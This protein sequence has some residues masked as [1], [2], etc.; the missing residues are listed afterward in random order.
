MQRGDILSLMFVDLKL[1]IVFQYCRF[2]T[3]LAHKICQ[4]KTP[5]KVKSEWN[6]IIDL[7]YLF[8]KFSVYQY[9]YSLL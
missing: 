7:F 2:I 9:L 1:V 6:Y 3:A 5:N 8:V 4:K